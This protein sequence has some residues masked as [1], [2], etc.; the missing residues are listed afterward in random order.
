MADNSFEN[1]MKSLMSGANGVLTSKTVVGNAVRVGD[2]IIIPLSDVTIGAG[3]GS[4]NSNGKNAGTG[5]FSAKMSP[6][7][8]LI[9][10]DGKTKVVNI[11]DQNTLSRF[12]D[13]VPEAID[14]IKEKKNGG[15]TMD[16]DEAVD[17]AFP[18][19][20]EKQ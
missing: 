1:V 14:K 13:M 17:I 6:S 3:A 12:I 2:T 18:D 20:K 15:V 8:V 10:Q 5:G 4:N 9:V 16:S 11:K 7:A 19:E